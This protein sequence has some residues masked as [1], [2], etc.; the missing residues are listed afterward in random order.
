MNQELTLDEIEKIS[1]SFGN[2][3]YVTLTGGEPSLRSDLP[4]IARI[5]DR[6]NNVQFLSIPTNSLMPDRIKSIAE[7]ILK[8][9]KNP[10][11]KFCLSLDG[12]GNKHDEIRGVPGCFEKVVENYNNLAKLKKEIKDFDIM[13]NMTISSYNVDNVAEVMDFVCKEMPE[14]IFDF[15]WSRGDV[16]DK[17]SRNITADDYSRINNLFGE[18]LKKYSPNF[19]FSGIMF[20][21]KMIMRDLI[22]H[23]LRGGKRFY[24]CSAGK[25]M[26]IISENGDIKP[27]ETLGINFGNLKDYNYD[28]MKALGTD[29]A[30]K[31]LLS[32]KAKECSCTFENALQCSLA[33]NIS[34]WPLVA[35]K[36]LKNIITK[37]N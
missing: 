34:A 12:I 9:T 26:V 1:R 24:A 33:Y 8:T 14:A 27:C 23:N 29:K 20:A 28:I 2:L 30:K 37:N 4:A 31:T 32:I 18:K 25:D 35:K 13:L 22:L 5:F 3:Q 6:N 36:I 15:G 19:V 10:R 17:A 7:E 16:R 21:N 11:L